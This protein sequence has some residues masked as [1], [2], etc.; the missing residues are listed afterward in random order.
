MQRA[1]KAPADLQDRLDAYARGESGGAVVVWLDADSEG[2]VFCQTGT[3]SAADHRPITADTVF[4]IGSI[5]KVFTALLLAES[6]R[7]GRVALL[8]SAAKYLM[9]A[10]HP[11]QADLAKITLLSLVTHTSGIPLPDN[12][13]LHQDV[14]NPYAHYERESLVDAL[15][16]LGPTAVGGS[17]EYSNFGSA[18]LGEALAAAW[19]T[20]Y[21]E[22]LQT[23]I[24]KPLGLHLTSIGL[25]GQSA[26]ADLAPGHANGKMVPNWTFK[27]FAPAGALRS[28]ARELALFLSA[29]LGIRQTTLASTIAATLQPQYPAATVGGSVALGWMLCGDPARPIVFHTGATAG[30]IA[31]V[32]FDRQTGSGVA[33]LSNF[34]KLSHE[35][36][37]ALLRPPPNESL[38]EVAGVDLR[39][40]PGVYSVTPEFILTVS[41]QDDQLFVQATGQVKLA[42]FASAHDEFFYRAENAQI[43]FQRDP[44]GKVTGLT[45][46]QHGQHFP[47]GRLQD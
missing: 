4:E 14:D 39:D 44:S 26:P 23:H 41:A 5:S 46:H 21:A 43:S 34:H 31:F 6:D 36:G 13:G 22:A 10:D 24:L 38:Q 19:G 29:C 11:A 3:Y 16:R 37:F 2:P 27:A 20:S 35:L 12:A 30:S 18:I 25:A 9:P 32:G 28:S 17:F 47:A 42:V 7:L 1:T 33:I 15:R 45:V 8:D 40:Y